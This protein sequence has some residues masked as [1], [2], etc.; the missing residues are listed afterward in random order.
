MSGPRRLAVFL[1]AAWFGFV[2]V[3]YVL[4]GGPIKWDAVFVFGF[5]PVVLTW[6]V[7][8]VWRGFRTHSE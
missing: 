7:W 3:A 8:W 2:L 5:V 6:G 4:D 1:S